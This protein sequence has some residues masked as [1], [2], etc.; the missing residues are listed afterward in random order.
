MYTTH[1]HI[2]TPDSDLTIWRYMDL[3]KFLDIIEN[4][5]LYLTRLD[6]FE[7]KFEGRI[8]IRNVR[9]LGNNSQLKK[10]DS[11]SDI[12]L[13]TSTYVS[14]WS[15]ETNETYP[16]W[17]IY[18]DYRTAVAIKTTVGNLIESI[19][20]NEQNQYLGKVNYVKPKGKYLF[21]GNFFQ[22]ALDKREYF[23]FENEVRIITTLSGANYDELLKLPLGLKIN[24]DANKLIEE[25]Y[26]APLADDNLKSL[27]ELKLKE[28]NINKDVRFSDI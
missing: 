15:I 13:K 26:L 25:I 14:S 19:S 11:Y 18:S 7:D 24:I 10:I 2:N 1:P 8:P 16:L 21:K 28:I 23:M 9:N 5:K 17:K 3:W 20:N 12:A 6:Q 4:N 22:L 27:I